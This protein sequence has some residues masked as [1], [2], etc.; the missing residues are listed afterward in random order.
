MSATVTKED[1]PRP[2]IA[3]CEECQDGVRHATR[4]RAQKW[5]DRHNE[6]HHTEEV[7]PK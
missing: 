3:W 6:E 1:G 7:S 4:T 5:A 2:F